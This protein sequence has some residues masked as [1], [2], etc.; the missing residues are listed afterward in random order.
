[1][2]RHSLRPYYL[3]GGILLIKATAS[4]FL[5]SLTT[6]RAWQLGHRLAVENSGCISSSPRRAWSRS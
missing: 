2:F 4:G 1:M 6:L 5:L 3:M